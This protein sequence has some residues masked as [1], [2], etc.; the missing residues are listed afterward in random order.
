MHRGIYQTTFDEDVPTDNDRQ[1]GCPECSGR[2]TT[3]S[4]ETVCEDCGLVIDAERVNP[5]PEWRSFDDEQESCE[6]TGAPRTPSRHDRGLSTR[7]GQQAVSTTGEQGSARKR[8]Q[9][10]RLRREHR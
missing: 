3:I 6:R 7:I 4:H 10:S 9:L 5:G 2:I 8:R 1:R